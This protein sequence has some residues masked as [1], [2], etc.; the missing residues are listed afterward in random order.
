MEIFLEEGRKEGR[1][2]GDLK[3]AQKTAFNMLKDG[4][5]VDRV[6]R[7]LE[8]PADTIRTWAKEANMPV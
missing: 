1:E 4:D 8:L 3:R 7:L 2:E 5:P 6:A